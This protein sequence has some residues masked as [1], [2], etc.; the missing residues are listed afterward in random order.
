MGFILVQQFLE[1]VKRSTQCEQSIILLFT[2]LR[3]RRQTASVI[4]PVE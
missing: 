3:V 2:A 4:L 1:S